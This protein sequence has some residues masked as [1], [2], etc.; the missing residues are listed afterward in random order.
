MYHIMAL[1]NTLTKNFTI[2]AVCFICN[3]PLPE[4]ESEINAHVDMCIAESMTTQAP[5]EEVSWN[6]YSW[7]GETRVRATS[8][9]EGGWAGKPIT[10]IQMEFCIC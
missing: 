3:F 2:P 8:L 7:D 4:S 5:E 1:S 10:S 9:M 6:E